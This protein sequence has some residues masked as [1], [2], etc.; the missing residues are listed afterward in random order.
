MAKKMTRNSYKRRIIVIGIM[1]FACIALIS[2]G[3]AAWIISTNATNEQNGNISVGKVTDS[4]ITIENVQLSTTNFYFEPAE[5]DFTGRLRNQEGDPS[6]SL[7]VTV[8]G[9]IHNAQYLSELKIYLD[10]TQAE[11]VK[12]AA[13]ANYI[14]L[15]ECAQYE[16]VVSDLVVVNETTKSFSFVVEFK[17]GSVFDG[18]NP[19]LYYDK[20]YAN[21]E[22]VDEDTTPGVAKYLADKGATISDSVMGDTLKA[23]RKTMYNGDDSFDASA[24]QVDM[25]FTIILIGS[26]N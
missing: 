20:Y 26:V 9:E 15:P 16:V 18:I 3:F 22:Y 14:V 4:S 25:A 2:T 12:A 13:A 17:W 19:S 24:D 1:I 5:N 21:P 7:S 6:E 8:T 10:L 23:F 11:G